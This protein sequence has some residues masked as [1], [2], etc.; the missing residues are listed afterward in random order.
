M[1][2]V[3]LAFAVFCAAS[4]GLK[5]DFTSLPVM[6]EFEHVISDDDAVMQLFY[7]QNYEM[8][9]IDDKS[10]QAKSIYTVM[11]SKKKWFVKIIREGCPLC[12]TTFFGYEWKLKHNKKTKGLIKAGGAELMLPDKSAIFMLEGKKHLIISYPWAPGKTLENIYIDYLLDN[13]SSEVLKIAMYRYGQVLATAALDPNNPNDDIEELLNRRQHIQLYDR[14]GGNTKYFERNDKIYMFDL[15][16][17]ALNTD[18][19]TVVASIIMN[20][21]YIEHLLLS[22]IKSDRFNMVESEIG[23]IML[24]SVECLSLPFNQFISGYISAL[25]KY[26]SDV[27]KI[28]LIKEMYDLFGNNCNSGIGVY[29]NLIKGLDLIK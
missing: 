26:D 25:P 12:Y 22:G 4:T 18:H 5:A 14:N 19:N 29:C 15:S 17:T 28:M 1:N 3:L 2:K 16:K 23:E 9:K 8:L 11:A 7:N 20:F 21:K 27:I 10:S 24:D 6:Q 13:E